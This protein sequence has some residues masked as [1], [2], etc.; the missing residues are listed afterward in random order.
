V[1]PLLLLL[2]FCTGYALPTTSSRITSTRSTAMHMS[3]AYHATHLA[4][5]RAAGRPSASRSRSKASIELLTWEEVRSEMARQCST[6]R[7]SRLILF[8]A[9]YC[10]FCRMIT[11]RL[12]L[13]VSRMGED[14]Q[15]LRVNHN[16][17]TKGIFEQLQIERLPTLLLSQPGE[18]DQLIPLESISS[19]TGLEST[20]LDRHGDDDVF[21]A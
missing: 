4:D 14:A 18:E 7:E 12:N 5:L 20:L 17:A 11:P 16:L 13:L 15:L 19:L 2:P 10:R 1:L 8:G 6:S 3:G 9:R 21:A